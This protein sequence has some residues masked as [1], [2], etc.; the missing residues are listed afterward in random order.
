MNQDLSRIA[1]FICADLNG[2][3]NM[4]TTRIFNS[5]D[6]L[7]P[8]D[9]EPIRSIV[10]ESQDAT[11]VAWFVLPNQT[12]SPHTHPNGQDTW[13]VLSGSGEY[14]LDKIGNTRSII[15]GDIVVAHR[16]SVHGVLNNSKNPLIFIS[17]VTPTNAGYQLITL[18]DN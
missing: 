13:T 18:E 9:G 6:F 15:A 8:T 5:S 10:T 12:I 14:Y 3:N 7:Q 11:V 17:V 2:V 1:Y 4:N 16:N